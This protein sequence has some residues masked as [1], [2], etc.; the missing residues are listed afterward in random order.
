MADLTRDELRRLPF[1]LI[2]FRGIGCDLPVVVATKDMHDFV[3][4]EV[5]GD[6]GA[7][8]RD[9]ERRERA[10]DPFLSRCGGPDWLNPAGCDESGPLQSER[11]RRW[12]RRRRWALTVRPAELVGGPRAEHGPLHL[13]C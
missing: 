8:T 6:R 4:G 10:I 3:L 7:V 1:H 12:R 13:M 9:E 2:D 11:R 5:V